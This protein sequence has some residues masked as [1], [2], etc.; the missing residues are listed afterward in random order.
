M[1]SHETSLLGVRL[2]Q[3]AAVQLVSF[4]QDPQTFRSLPGFG[5]FAFAL[6][7]E[8]QGGIYPLP[9]DVVS[10]LVSLLLTSPCQSTEPPKHRQKPAVTL[11]EPHN[12][13]L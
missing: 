3:K 4:D 2:P 13:R 7:R 5:P 6:T 11:S 10:L 1:S 9:Q 12:V 8:T